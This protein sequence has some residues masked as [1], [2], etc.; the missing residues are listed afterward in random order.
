MCVWV[1]VFC[2]FHLQKAF[3]L[4]T[5]K[6]DVC[7][8]IQVRLRKEKASVAEYLASRAVA[9]I[10]IAVPLPA[11]HKNIPAKYPVHYAV[12]NCDNLQGKDRASLYYS[13]LY[14]RHSLSP[15]LLPTSPT[16]SPSSPLTPLK[17]NKH[18]QKHTHTH[19]NT[20][21]KTLL[22]RLLI[23]EPHPHFQILTHLQQLT[24]SGIS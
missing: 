16:S 21:T 20:H 22:M 12:Y 17:Q 14:F 4:S 15:F 13:D 24:E 6:E 9:G 8:T 11:W 2:F 7:S 23:T 18:T 5:E 1:F 3:E 19:T 10:F